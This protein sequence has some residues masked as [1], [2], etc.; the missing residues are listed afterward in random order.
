[1]SNPPLLPPPPFGWYGRGGGLCGGAL[2]VGEGE[3]EDG[4]PDFSVE[5]EE[6]VKAP[7]VFAST[8]PKDVALLGRVYKPNLFDSGGGAGLESDYRA[9]TVVAFLAGE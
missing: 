5:D 2:H 8:H 7:S 3:D 9:Q 4:P 6:A 1:M